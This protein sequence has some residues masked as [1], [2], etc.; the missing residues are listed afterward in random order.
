MWLIA[1]GA[2]LLPAIA[3]VVTGVVVNSLVWGIGVAAGLFVSGLCIALL[4]TAVV[5]FR[6]DRKA[7]RGE[8]GV[9]EGTGRR[10]S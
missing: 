1:A 10:S 2:Y 8:D 4:V 5:S 6:A 3:G 7:V 9:R